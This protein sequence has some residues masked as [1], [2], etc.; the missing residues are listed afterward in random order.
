MSSDSEDEDFA[1]YGIPLDPL[2]EGTINKRLK[3][4]KFNHVET[5]CRLG[6]YFVCLCTSFASGSC[7]VRLTSSPHKDPK[8]A[9][10]S[11]MSTL[12][13]CTFNLRCTSTSKGEYS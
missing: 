2:N 7:P 5:C 10:G 1:E 6:I 11:I 13:Q 3:T 9:A 4:H 12:P 8:F